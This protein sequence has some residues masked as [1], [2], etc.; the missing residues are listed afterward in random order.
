M[1]RKALVGGEGSGWGRVWEGMNQLG[2]AL[3]TGNGQVGVNGLGGV[4]GAVNESNGW[5]LLFWG[6]DPR[7]CKQV[8]ERT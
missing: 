3:G 1:G 4:V 8:R 5:Y 6:L 7:Q 2:A